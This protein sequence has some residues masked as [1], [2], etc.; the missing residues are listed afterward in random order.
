MSKR[1]ELAS[2]LAVLGI[3]FLAIGYWVVM[4]PMSIHAQEETETEAVEEPEEAEQDEPISV[5]SA[6]TGENSFCLVCHANSTET[7]TLEDG[8]VIS[9]QV[10]TDVLEHS[11]HGADNEEGALGCVDCHGSDIFPHDGPYPETGRAYTVQASLMCTN[12][13]VEQTENLA[14]GVH[15]TAL[16]DGNLLSASCVDCHGGHEVETPNKVLTAETCGSCH[17]ST[18]EEYHDSVHGEALFAGDE[19]VP[20]CTDCHGVHGIQ[21]PTTA[22]FRNRSPELCATCHA[23]QEL[24]EEYDISTN[25]FNSYLSDFH[26][27]TVSL[28][29][30]TDPNVPT[31]KAVCYD[32]HGVHDITEADDS[33]GQVVRENLLETCQECHPGATS[34]FSD[35]W[36]G[37][38][39]PTFESHPLLFA[40]NLFYDILIPLVITGFVVLVGVDIIGRIRRRFGTRGES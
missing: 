17:V 13:H 3:V 2:A 5:A 37:H 20:T 33:K 1:T 22:L 7:L 19:N 38:F 23:D 25:V 26:G 8:T 36:V 16:A 15:Y 14:D 40:V 9:A 18:A 10:D 4:E 12:C 29:A 6:P 21:H 11:V 39:E 24:M 30:Q 34:D 27:T 35:T 31:N 32:C 28:F